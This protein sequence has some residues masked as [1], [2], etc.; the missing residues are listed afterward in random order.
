MACDR[1]PIAWLSMAQA[2]TRQDGYAERYGCQQDRDLQLTLKSGNS[3][4]HRQYEKNRSIGILL[5][6]FPFLMQRS[7]SSNKIYEEWIQKLSQEND[8]GHSPWDPKNYFIFS[9]PFM[10]LDLW[11][12]RIKTRFDSLFLQHKG[13]AFLF[14]TLTN[15]L[16]QILSTEERV[17]FAAQLPVWEISS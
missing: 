5:E 7:G 13:L 6:Q 15:A 8:E 16:F 17:P 9:K 11:G 10:V 3:R 1:L 4:Q 14:M 12:G 2:T